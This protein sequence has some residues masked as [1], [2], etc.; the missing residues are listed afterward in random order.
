[1]G[2]TV[3]PEGYTEFIA[4][5]RMSDEHMRYLESCA[6]IRSVSVQGLI[7]RLLL[8]VARDRLVEGIADGDDLRKIDDG[9]STRERAPTDRLFDA[10]PR[11][12]KYIVTG[13]EGMTDEVK[14]R[15]P[16]HD[17]IAPKKGRPPARKSPSIAPSVPARRTGGSVPIT[18]VGKSV[19]TLA[20]QPQKTKGELRRE[21]EEAVRNTAAMPIDE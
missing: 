19:R 4:R 9:I 5:I 12:S 3:V 13:I 7:R 21:L 11:K 15:S 8:I 10:L 20:R 2:N 18:R 16:R 17:T 6:R 1:M 14:R